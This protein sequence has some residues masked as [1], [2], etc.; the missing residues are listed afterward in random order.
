MA[1]SFEQFSKKV[2][3]FA[4]AIPVQ[5]SKGLRRL[6]LVCLTDIVYSTPVDTGRARANWQVTIGS[7]PNFELDE[8]D[9]TGALT[10]A[11]G[12]NFLNGQ[13]KEPRTIYITNN[14]AYIGRLNDGYS[15]QAPANF[16]QHAVQRGIAFVRNAKIIQYR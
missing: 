1:I 11:N 9:P 13:D 14:V 6:A 2:Q 4:A 16:V 5:A 8:E 10:I 3:R 7:I 12:A 15:A